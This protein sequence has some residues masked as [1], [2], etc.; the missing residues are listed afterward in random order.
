MA[1]AGL[2]GYDDM[3]IDE[4]A[5]AMAAENLARLGAAGSGGDSHGSGGESVSGNYLGVEGNAVGADAAAQ[6]AYAAGFR[7]SDLAS[8][9]A[10]GGRES[11]WTNIKSQSSDDWGIWQINGINMNFLKKKGIVSTKQD[12]LNPNI[13]ARAAYA[14]YQNDG[15]S[16]WKASASSSTHG[17]GA[18]FDGN[19]D[20][21][22]RTDDFMSAAQVASSNAESG[23]AVFDKSPTTHPTGSAQP[24]GPRSVSLNQPINVTVSPTI[25]VTAS[26]NMDL[27]GIAD[28][29]A[30]MLEAKVR[31]LNLRSS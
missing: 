29:I 18:G 25:N 23:D 12:L 8:I 16:P 1:T 22:W 14:L 10:I 11:G 31:E 9:V 5:N 19:G 30:S 7:G 17:G 20:H 28:T 3:A 21:M 15:F 4:I 24:S 27:D 13:N 6:A 26:N 2:R